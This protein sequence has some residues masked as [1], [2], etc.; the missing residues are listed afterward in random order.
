MQPSPNQP[1]QNRPT[2]PSLPAKPR[3]V[4]GGFKLSSGFNSAD[5]G[6]I[7][8][9]TQRW[10][11][12]LEQAAPGPRLVEGLE[13]GRL[14]QTKRLEFVPGAVKAQVQGRQYRPYD[15][16]L[17][18]TVF[19]PEQWEQVVGLMADQAVY[20][21]KLLAGELPA[22]IEE[23]FARVGVRLF[24]LEVSDVTTSCTC[25][26]QGEWCKH[27]CCVAAL[28]ADQLASKPFLMFE[29][30]GISPSDLMEH[31]RQ[32]RT[33]SAAGT[34]AVPIYTPHAEGEHPSKPLEECTE[35]FWDA[36]TEIGD[37]DLPLDP[38]AVSHPLLRRLGPSPFAGAKF[39]LVGLLA[40]C[41]EMV[42]R[43][44][45]EGADAAAAAEASDDPAQPADDAP[46]GDGDQ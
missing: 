42:S 38:P 10:I 37:I 32:R 31:V 24:P 26:A 40:T 3:R 9:T 20:A 39:P 22:N 27:A 16:T 21:A 35:D 19:T 13:Y 44:A 15:T 36:G 23:I 1:F 25:G 11:R 30:R 45:L 46:D 7:P 18:L 12:V 34:S 4:R 2:Q 29:L 5:A 33:M 14:G 6:P 43:S 41:Y 17:K 8:W 28:V